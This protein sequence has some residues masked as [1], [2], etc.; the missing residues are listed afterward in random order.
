MSIKDRLLQVQQTIPEHVTL[1]AVSK[2]MS[3]NAILEAY[4]AGQ[5]HFG[6]N[7]VQELVE[8]QA[9]LPNNIKWH[10]IGHLQTNK[11]KFIVPFVDLIEGVDSLKLLKEINKQA[12]KNKRIQR[13]LLQFFIADEET[14]FG[15]SLKEA[16]ELLESIKKE[17]LQA[18]EIYGVMGMATYTD[19]ENQI[20]EE[21]RQLKS[22]FDELKT[23]FFSDSAAF[24]IV[25][26][27]M[28]GDYLLAIAEGSNQV[29]IGST[30]F[31]V[32]IYNT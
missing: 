3:N 27:G 12:L 24:Q 13:C 21:F 31:G 20:R 28:S 16:A 23:G 22:I 18:V 1:V 7:K 14:K 30:I 5:R 8:K 9:A 10:F 15:L 32:R 19:N 25:S 6:E 29:R 2:T 4:E 26:M 11:V 17:P